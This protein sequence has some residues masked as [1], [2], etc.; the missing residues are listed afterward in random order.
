VRVKEEKYEEREKRE[1]REENMKK[2]CWRRE[3][4]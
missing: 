2:G 4:N 1:E 3:R